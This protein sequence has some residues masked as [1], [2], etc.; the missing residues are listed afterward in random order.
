MRAK[1]KKYENPYNVRPDVW[2]YKNERSF[3]FFLSPDGSRA[4][5][6]SFVIQDRTLLRYING[7]ARDKRRGK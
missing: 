5:D 6:R 3:E 4:S 1:R 7:S 2:F